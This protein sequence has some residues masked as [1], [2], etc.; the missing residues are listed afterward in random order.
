MTAAVAVRHLERGP[1][2]TV[3][4]LLLAS[5]VAFTVVFPLPV[6]A[7]TLGVIGFLVMFF[8]WPAVIVVIYGLALGLDALWTAPWER[9]LTWG[10]MVWLLFHPVH[11]RLRGFRA[12]YNQA[13]LVGRSWRGPGDGPLTPWADRVQ[14]VLQL[15]AWPALVLWGGP[16]GVGIA[17][18]LGFY[19]TD[20]RFTHRRHGVP[21]GW[22]ALAGAAALA[23]LLSWQAWPWFT[24]PEIPILLRVVGLPFALLVAV[25]FGWFALRAAW[26]RVQAQL[27]AAAA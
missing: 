21:A 4:G 17:A 22:S 26:Y 18:A 2:D 7:L 6:F 5:I 11:E 1:E 19:V 14:L 16:V 12:A 9:W 8:F 20:Y 23:L 24:A 27:G 15:T 10:V 13:S 3:A 25:G